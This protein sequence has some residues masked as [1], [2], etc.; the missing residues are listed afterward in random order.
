MRLVCYPTSV[1]PPKI[2]A[3]PV[4]RAWMDRTEQGFAYRCLPLNI[5]NA[6]GWLVLNTVPFVAQWDGG[7]GLDAISL[8]AHAADTPLLAL[9]HFGHGVLTFNVNALFRT[10]PGYDL[11]VTG[12]LN[13]P[14]DGP[15]PLTG[16]VETDWAP[17]TFTMN[18]KFTRKLTPIPFDRDEPFCMI[19]PLKRGLVEQFQPEIRALESDRE[20]C[21]AYFAWADSRR[22]F[23]EDLRVPGS[24]AQAQKWQKDY[25]R[26]LAPGRP[27]T[28]PPPGRER[29]AGVPGAGTAPPDHRTKLKLREF[30]STS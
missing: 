17:F 12:P 30:R 21:E 16:V 2:V 3:A 20:V 28:K 4:E 29:G 22:A 19:F 1:E 11:M 8:Y 14:K 6:H 25:F 7:P 15:Q 9:S 18:W 23:N 5:A 27:P 26:G 24:Q 10:E 13:L